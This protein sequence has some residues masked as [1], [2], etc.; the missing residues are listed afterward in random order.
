MINYGRVLRL[1]KG[2]TI[3]IDGPAAS[4]KS[5][6]ARLV[7]NELG[8]IHVDTGAM[9]RALTLEV[10]RRNIDLSNEKDIFE[11]AKQCNIETKQIS[12][13]TIKIML[14]GLDVTNEIRRPEVSNAV[15]TVSS[16]KD[17]RELMVKKQ[18]AIAEKGGVVLEG[19]DIG[20]IVYPEAEL[21]IF[22]YAEVDER[23]KRRKKELEASGIKIDEKHLLNEIELRDLK[24]S[25]RDISPLRKAEDALLLD[26]TKLKIEEQVNYILKQARKLIKAQKVSS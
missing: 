7:A 5:T 21:K 24:D 10:L 6:T 3:A 12:D 18:R 20:T 26:T 9:Y 16:Y 19:R 11:V 25:S 4:G 1:L 13:G 14:N 17:I 15:S 8:Y 22:M 2:I 23:A